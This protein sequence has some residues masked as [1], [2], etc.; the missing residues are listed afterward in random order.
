MPERPEGPRAAAR[1]RP[2]GLDEPGVCDVLRQVRTGALSARAA[3]ERSLNAIGRLNGD[4][5]AVVVMDAARAR[6]RADALDRERAAGRPVGPL[7][8]LPMT[9]KESFDV[10]G[11]PT[12]WGDPARADNTAAES[13]EVVRRLEAADAVILGKTNVAQGL[14]DWE[15]RNPLFGVTRNPCDATRSAGGS[16][17]GSA[18]A[19]ASGMVSADIGSD[20]GGSIR[21]PAHYCGIF[22][23]KPTWNLIPMIGHSLQG[24]LRAPDIAVAGPLARR[25]ED[26]AVLLSALAG[27]AEMDAAGWTVQLPQPEPRPPSSYRLAALLDHG[28]CP[29]DR[30]YRDVMEEFIDSLRQ[31]GVTVDLSVLPDVSFTRATELM[32]LLVRAETAT[33]LSEPAF[34][35]AV[36][37]A[38]E[39]R[40]DDD[41]HRR[42]N[43]R[44]AALAHRDWLRLHEER[45]RIRMAWRRFFAGYDAFLCP[46]AASAAPPL[47]PGGELADRTI[48]VNGRPQPV[49][50]QHFWSAVASVPYLPAVVMPIG[51]TAEGLPLG[52]QVMGPADHDLRVIALASLLHGHAEDD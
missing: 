17:G 26:L 22:G 10:A 15:T 51:T 6:G 37:G 7:H 19:V 21:I 42:R 38:R 31:S 48:E 1:G 43:A 41:G 33:R 12:S 4:L 23:L 32:N 52:L 16:S 36:S 45:Q 13:S 34:Q 44:G 11:L 14:A 20:H 39:A 47:A 30:P 40:P 46:V 24:D 50:D 25:A 29:V 28:D 35:E 49:L 3:L 8:G 2:D 27:P 9:V 5:N 18:A